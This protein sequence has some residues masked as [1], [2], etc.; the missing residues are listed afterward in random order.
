MDSFRL[1][2]A[3]AICRSHFGGAEAN[4]NTEGASLNQ[5]PFE[6]RVWIIFAVWPVL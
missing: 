5:V 1:R 2:S 4:A 3:A 6:T